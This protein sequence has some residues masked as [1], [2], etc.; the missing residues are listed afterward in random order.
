[1]MEKLPQFPIDDRKVAT[2]SIYEEKLPTFQ[3][4]KESCHSFQIKGH[5]TG[6][7]KSRM[8]QITYYSQTPSEGQPS[9]L[10]K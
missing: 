9:S 3:F 10:P 5:P 6:F 8:I 2:L 4:M 7:P 1:M